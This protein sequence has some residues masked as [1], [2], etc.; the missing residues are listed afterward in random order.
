MLHVAVSYVQL[1]CNVTAN[2]EPKAHDIY[3]DK[4]QDEWGGILLR[5]EDFF[6]QFEPSCPA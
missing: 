1:K 3:I 5:Y 4:V 6:S 2:V